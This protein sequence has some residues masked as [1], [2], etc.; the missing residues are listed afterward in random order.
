MSIFSF[1]FDHVDQLV[2]DVEISEGL[3][4]DLTSDPGNR[5]FSDGPVVNPATGLPMVDDSFCG[6]DVGGS[7][8]GMDIHESALGLQDTAFNFTDDHFLSSQDTWTSSGSGGFDV[9]W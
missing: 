1:L 4:G 3:I 8:F 2:N 6:V 9:E 5:L 7:P